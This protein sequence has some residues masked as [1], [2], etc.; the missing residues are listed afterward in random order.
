[1]ASPVKKTKLALHTTWQTRAQW[2]A[3]YKV[4]KDLKTAGFETYF[5]GGCVRDLLL[6]REP[7]DFDVATSASPEEVE[8][9]FKKTVAVGRAFGV[10]KVLEKGCEVE[11]ARFRQESEYKDGRRPEKIDFSSAEKDASR[12]DFTVNGLFWDVD[13][14]QVIDHVGGLE[15]LQAQLIRAIG[16]PQERF[17]EDHLRLLRA[18]RFQ[19]QLGFEIESL[20]A[21]AVW[22][23]FELVLKVSRER[24]REEFEKLIGGP[25]AVPTL[26]LMNEKEVLGVLFPG[27][28]FAQNALDEMRGWDDF[29]LWCWHSGTTQESLRNNWRSLRASNEWLQNLESL[30]EPFFREKDFAHRELGELVEK[31]FNDNFN[32]GLLLWGAQRSGAEKDKIEKVQELRNHWQLRAPAAF[33]SGQDLQGLLSGPQLGECLRFLYQQQL[34]LKVQNREQALELAK[35]KFIG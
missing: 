27:C 25:F 24:F 12:R 19:A 28:L 20:T 26:R 16:V 21:Q 10:V 13:A 11:V 6:G 4:W 9:L 2:V 18:L 15:D 31:S 33:L 34:E 1:M 29:W 32:K 8:G 3:A 23:N 5:A 14:E 17:Q 30:F 22:E 7:H 35:R